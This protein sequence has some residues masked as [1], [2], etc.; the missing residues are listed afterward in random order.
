MKIA[1]VTGEVPSP[2]AG[3]IATVAHFLH[4]GLEERGISADF[5]CSAK[6]QDTGF[7]ATYLHQSGPH[8][9][10]DLTFGRSFAKLGDRLA[11]YDVVDFHLP[12]A[13]GPLLMHRLDPAR[14][15]AT[16]HT[17]SLGYKRNVYDRLPFAH[18]AKNEKRQKA[19]FINIA[20]ALERRAL[21]RAAVINCVSDNLVTEA[22]DWYGH[23]NV[24]RTAKAVELPETAE[25][26][27]KR[28]ADAPFLFIG[29]MVA[30]KGLFDLVEAYAQS[31][32]SRPLELVGD[33]ALRSQLE[34]QVAERGLNVR[35]LGYQDRA[36]VMA[37]LARARA[38]VVPSL[39]ETQPMVAFEAAA[40][41][42]PVI[43]YKSAAI[44]DAVVPANQPFILPCGDVAGLAAS[45][46][47]M[48][49][50]AALAERLG[51]ANRAHHLA[52][53]RYTKM[54]DDYIAL[55]EKVAGT[56]GAK[57]A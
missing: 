24:V 33:G 4:Q 13:R 45:L 46:K 10:H 26:T 17:T 31:G 25:V 27:P 9:I 21:K 51:A 32:T 14:C 43:G 12:N 11:G 55:Y 19:G 15:I 47:Q 28:A 23:Q 36:G 56:S 18:L 1:I 38:L 35:F 52:T 42:L 20:I 48:D 49:Q 2:K 16:L 34:A 5:Y 6:Y 39:Y 7:P 30:Q 54:I 57:A 41:A 53:D 50:D 22:R 44:G 29:R 3:G 8:P 40:Q 37:A